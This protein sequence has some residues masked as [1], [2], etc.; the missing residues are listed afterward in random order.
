MNTSYGARRRP[1]TAA[2]QRANW[3]TAFE[4]SGLSAAAF[5]RQHD[6][7][8]TTFCNWRQR[9]GKARTSPGFVQIELPPPAAV[10]LVLELGRGARLRITEASQIALAVRLLQE[11]DAPRPC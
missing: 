7:N 3:L 5:A 8:Y 10:E 4:R 11:L 9:E 6:L 1:R 2:A